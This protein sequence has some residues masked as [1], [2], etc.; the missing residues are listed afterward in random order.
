[1]QCP[2][3]VKKPVRYSDRQMELATVM[4]CTPERAIDV[5]ID[6]LQV[7]KM[8]LGLQSMTVKKKNNP[9]KVKKLAELFSAYYEL[10]KHFVKEERTKI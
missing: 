1:M 2:N 6:A 9:K 4:G 8:V 5:L 3:E 10:E 7:I